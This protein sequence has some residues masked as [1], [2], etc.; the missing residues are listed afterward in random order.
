MIRTTLRP[1]QKSCSKRRW[2]F[3]CGSW[4]HSVVLSGLYVVVLSSPNINR[5][6]IGFIR[7][8]C[9]VQQLGGRLLLVDRHSTP[10]HCNNRHSDC[11][12]QEFVKMHVSDIL[13]IPPQA[14][15]TGIAK[16]SILPRTSKPANALHGGPRWRSEAQ[17]SL[18]SCARVLMVNLL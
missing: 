9:G 15:V 10:R 14:S 6:Y 7:Y 4:R 5:P 2:S 1:R 12:F 11:V 18:L 13:R 3:W 17:C 16:H 8:W